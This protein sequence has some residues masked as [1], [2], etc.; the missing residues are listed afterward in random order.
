M[1]GEVVGEVVTEEEGAMATAAGTEEGAAGVRGDKPIRAM[2][3]GE[4][5]GAL[6][7]EGGCGVIAYPR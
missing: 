3:A 5:E 4:R 6:A 7:A 2:E 1:G